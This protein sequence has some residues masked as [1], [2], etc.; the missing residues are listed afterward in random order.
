MAVAVDGDVVVE[1][2]QGGEVVGVVGSAV[3]VGD[4]V[5]GLEPVAGV[6]PGDGASAVSVEHGAA[7]RWGDG[8]TVRGGGD[9]FAVVEADD[10]DRSVA[11]DLV[12]GVG[13][14]SG[15]GGD[16]GAGLSVACGGQ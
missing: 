9:G 3:A 11:E 2:A 16:F 7:Y 10:L 4:D 12:E 5:V 13:S 8:A 14:D 6:T 1:P 15:S